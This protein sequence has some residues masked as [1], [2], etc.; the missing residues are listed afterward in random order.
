MARRMFDQDR[1]P[2]RYPVHAV[3]VGVYE[4]TQAP[5]YTVLVHEVEHLAIHVHIRYT[6]FQENRAKRVIREEATTYLR[7]PWWN[8]ERFNVDFLTRWIT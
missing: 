1:I 7:G 4:C 2:D 5:E 6:W 3:T 8:Y